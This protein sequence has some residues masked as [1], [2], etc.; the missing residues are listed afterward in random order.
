MSGSGLGFVS[1]GHTWL[2]CFRHARWSHA[3]GEPAVFGCSVTAER[4]CAAA[5]ADCQVE[6]VTYVGFKMMWRRSDWPEWKNRHWIQFELCSESS[7][8]CVM[9]HNMLGDNVGE[10]LIFSSFCLPLSSSFSQLKLRESI[11]HF[12]FS[13]PMSSR[14]NWLFCGQTPLLDFR[15]GGALLFFSYIL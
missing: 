14:I 3:L 5:G 2:T 11:S 1:A 15:F 6:L 8:V 9:N 10:V 13:I 4:S 7:A 12:R